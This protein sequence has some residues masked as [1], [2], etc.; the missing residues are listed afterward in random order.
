[1][2]DKIRAYLMLIVIGGQVFSY[3]LSFVCCS[4]FSSIGIVLISLSFILIVP[5]PHMQIA[6]RGYMQCLRR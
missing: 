5:E 1:M 6:V 2:L 3:V 4:F